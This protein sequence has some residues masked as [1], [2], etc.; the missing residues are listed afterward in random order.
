MNVGDL[1][2]LKSGG[3]AMTITAADL[4]MVSVCWIDDF[5][6]K[7]ADL[8]RRCVVPYVEP[9]KEHSQDQPENLK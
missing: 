9:A 7:T 2:Q 1:V 8:D 6:F 4:S 3:P 5:G